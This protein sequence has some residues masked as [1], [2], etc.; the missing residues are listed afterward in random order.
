MKKKVLFVLVCAGV[1]CITSFSVIHAKEAGPIKLKYSNYFPATHRYA[2]LGA[3]FCE[4]IKKRTNGRVEIT[5]YPSGILTTAT[6]VLDGVVNAVSDIGLSHIEYTRGR[7]SVTETLNLPLGYSSGY[8]GTQVAND[9]YDKF[10]PKEW[11]PVHVLY[12]YSGG[13]GIIGTVKQ[14]V[15]TLEDLKGLK[16]RS[17]GRPADTVKALG[18]TPVPVEM[19]DL[20]EGLQR[21]VVDGLMNS[22]EALKGWK[23]GDLVRYATACWQVGS[24]YTFYVVMNK[25]KWNNLPDDIKKTFNEVAAEW[26]IKQ[27]TAVNEIDIEGMEYLKKSGGQVIQLTDQEAK[28]WEK[29]VEP[30]I[31][32]LFK[33]LEAKGFKRSETEAHLKFI[34]ERIAYWTQKEAEQN[35]IRPYR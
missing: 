35:I 31:E 4:E 13:P 34:R 14:P 18:A 11:E 29:A 25:T 6:K 27:G 24:V 10:K 19:A 20:Y 22:A 3:Q 16:I 17:A 21:G 23:F 7:F 8:V 5:Y 32:K 15:R 12:L 1:I 30:T 28:R 33:E 2:I 9:F 26:K